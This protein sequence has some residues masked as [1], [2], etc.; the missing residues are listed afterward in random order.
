MHCA[1]LV[2]LVRH[3]VPPHMYGAHEELPLFTQVPVPLQRSAGKKVDPEQLCAAQTV[4]LF[5]SAHFAE[6][7]HCPVRPHVL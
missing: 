3:V 5:H 7:S 6:P 4:P 2:Q 1:S